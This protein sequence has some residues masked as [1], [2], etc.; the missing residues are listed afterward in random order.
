MNKI[1]LALIFNANSVK[2][3]VFIMLNTLV[4]HKYHLECRLYLC[5]NA[6]L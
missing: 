5:A 2:T 4:K 1:I 3:N 6:L